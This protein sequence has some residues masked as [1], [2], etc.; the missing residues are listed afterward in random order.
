[1]QDA[2]NLLCEAK[3]Q[4]HQESGVGVLSLAGV[5]PELLLTPT[6]EVMQLNAII[7]GIKIS[8]LE[9]HSDGQADFMTGIQIAQ[10][11]LKHRANKTQR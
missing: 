9:N 10:L 2:A 5:R 6:S 4:Q 8:K 11:A 1:M 7:F 3:M